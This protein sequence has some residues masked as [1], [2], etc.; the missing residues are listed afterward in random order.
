MK[1]Y[2]NPIYKSI[3]CVNHDGILKSDW[4]CMNYTPATKTLNLF[5]NYTTKVS[6]MILIR[7]N[8]I[9]SWS[10]NLQCKKQQKVLNTSSA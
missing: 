6:L 10:A 4:I 5:L 8:I 3:L 2:Y 7:H 1:N 9:S